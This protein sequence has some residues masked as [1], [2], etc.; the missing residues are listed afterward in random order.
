MGVITEIKGQFRDLEAGYGV[1]PL[2]LTSEQRASAHFVAETAAGRTVRISLPR[3]TELQDGDLLEIDGDWAIVVRAAE[4]D[5]LFLSPGP[6][7]VQWAAACFQLGNLH[8]PARFLAEGILTPLDPMAVQVLSGFDVH[9]EQ[10]RRPFVGR[11]FGAVGAHHHHHHHTPEGGHSH[12][13]GTE[14]LS[15]GSG[16]G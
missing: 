2:L 10:V 8:R 14:T 11:R 6:D 15:N 5:L 7:P 13:L 16:D 4:E 1:D 3:G 9:V 12:S